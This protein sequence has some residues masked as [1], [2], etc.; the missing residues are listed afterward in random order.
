MANRRGLGF[1]IFLAA[2]TI[3]LLMS[4]G[5]GEQEVSWWSRVTGFQ[6]EGLGFDDFWEADYPPGQN[7]SFRARIRDGNLG[8]L[9]FS[10]T[11]GG[12][13]V[14]FNNG[15]TVRFTP[16]SEDVA[17]DRT[18]F[19]LYMLPFLGPERLG[20]TL[21]DIGVD[22]ALVVTDLN[23][24]GRDCFVVGDSLHIEEPA[25]EGA[26]PL[27]IRNTT[28]RKPAIYFDAE[29]GAVIRLITVDLTPIGVRLGDFRLFDHQ[30]RQ[31]VFLPTRFE[32]HA[33]N[34]GLRSRIRLTTSSDLK[35]HA[36]N[37][38]TIPDKI[39]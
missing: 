1:W 18:L 28:E 9:D 10:K 24:G 15:R 6:G 19:L 3:A 4:Q 17:V 7:L 30:L 5:C 2:V 12:Y 39:E 35:I 29:T 8:R 21:Y 23:W 13:S 14:I 16:E 26:A 37:L 20:K 38:Y 31:G 36:K 25:R 11:A 33:R 22:T 32:T 34:S 27:A